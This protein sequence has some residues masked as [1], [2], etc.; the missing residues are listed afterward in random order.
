MMMYSPLFTS[1]TMTDNPINQYPD[2]L[3]EQPISVLLIDDNP[4]D[5]ELAMLALRR[6]RIRNQI[7]WIRDGLEAL[8]FLFCRGQY[9]Q[10][11][12]INQP[13]IILLDLKLP[14]T[15]GIE[16]LRQLKLNI[17]TKIIP[18]VVFTSSAEESDIFASYQSGANSYVVKPVDSERFNQVVLEIIS[19]W[20]DTNKTAIF[21]GNS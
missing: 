15:N 1:P 11:T 9:L 13:K 2:T 6:H 16:I 5:A 8:D 21:A 4:S 10:R 3:T 17:D 19:Y 12:R 7:K 20:I 18:I 14:K